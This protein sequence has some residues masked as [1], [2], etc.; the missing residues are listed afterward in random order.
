MNEQRFGMLLAA[1]GAVLVL[2]AVL[3]DPIGIGGTEGEF[4]W[5][6][7]T[8]IG[9]GIV[10]LAAGAALAAGLLKRRRP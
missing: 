1:G 6:Q 7:W 3:A 4:G 9:V 10:S 8:G 5:K 2:L